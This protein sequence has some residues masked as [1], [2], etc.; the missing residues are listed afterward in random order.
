MKVTV[1]LF[2]MARELVDSSSVELELPDTEATTRG[3][4]AALVR[5]Y[6]ALSGVMRTAMLAVNRKYVDD[7]EDIAVTCKD[8][9]AVI[10][11]V[12]GG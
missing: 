8:E 2:A 11:P 7:D 1:L 3:I 12:S 6:P 10:P 4:T 5:E 9:I